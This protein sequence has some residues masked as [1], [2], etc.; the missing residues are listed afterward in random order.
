VPN[1]ASRARRQRIP[2]KGVTELSI[3]KRQPLRHDLGGEAQLKRLT[4]R[5]R[6]CRYLEL[7]PGPLLAQIRLAH[8]SRQKAMARSQLH[9]T[10]NDHSAYFVAGGSS[11]HL[12]WITVVGASGFAAGAVALAPGSGGASGV[13]IAMPNSR[14]CPPA[15]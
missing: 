7:A 9:A 5:G 8:R 11:T 1:A 2:R 6:Q 12:F 14:H 13:A 15:T 10:R 3:K 4:A